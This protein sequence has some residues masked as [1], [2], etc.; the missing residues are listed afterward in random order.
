M[1]SGRADK[2]ETFWVLNRKQLLC[3]VSPRRQDIVDKLAAQGPLSIRELAPQMGCSAPSLYHHIDQL[4]RAGLIVEAGHRVVRRKR[5]QIYATLAPRVRLKRA[6]SDPA[7]RALMA[8]IAAALNRQLDRDFRAGLR[9][10]GRTDGPQRNLGFFRLVGAPDAK[11]I[12]LINRRLDEI[13][14]ILWHAAG[15]TGELIS[16]GWT[17]APVGGRKRR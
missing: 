13:A 15:G 11:G 1:K 14:E 17:M 3:L 10:G 4:L 6:L 7:N 8:R 2:S 9:A 5:E 16:L 12:A